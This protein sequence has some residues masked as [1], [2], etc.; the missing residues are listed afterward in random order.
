MRVILTLVI[1][2]F[3]LPEPRRAKDRAAGE[4]KAAGTPPQRL[5][6]ALHFRH[7]GLIVLIIFLIS[8]VFSSMES[9]LAL[10]SEVQLAWG[11]RQVGY[12][13][14][15]AGVIAVICQGGLIG[16]LTRRFG[17]AWVV[18][19]ATFV[20]ALGMWGVAVAQ[21]LPPLLFAVACLAAGFGLGNPAL[22]SLVSRL[23]QTETT[24]GALGLSQ[25]TSSF[26]RV[27]G[28]PLAGLLFE[29]FGHAAPYVFGGLV[30][31]AVVVLA[32]ALRQ[33]LSREALA[34]TLKT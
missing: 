21:S 8:F 27:C 14:M 10:W 16:P 32:G 30:M 22:Q 33:R 29:R 5:I 3:F 11:P 23:S 26:A 17:E 2:A 19:G 4:V 28:P 15:F 25:S 24:G 7:I 34:A 1:A 6:A 18:V 13:F 20:L 12:L 9:T 31:M